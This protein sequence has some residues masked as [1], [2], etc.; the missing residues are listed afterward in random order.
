[1]RLAV[2]ELTY[3]SPGRLEWREAPDPV[4]RY[5][6]DAI[7]RPIASTTCDLDG[8]IIRGRALAMFPGPFAIGHECIAEV[9]ELGPGVGGLYPGQL[10]VVNWHISCGR[11]DRCRGGRPNTCRNH[12]PHACYGLPW[13]ERWGGTFSDLV[14]VPNANFALTPLPAGIDPVHVASAAD[15]LPFGYEFTIPH[16]GAAPGA[17]VLVMGGTG[18]IGLYAAMFAR[19]GGSS[20][21]DYVDTDPARL[22]VAEAL[23]VNAIESPPPRHMTARYPI[24][25]DTSASAEGLQC[26]VRSVEAEGVVSSCGGHFDNALPLPLHEMYVRGVHFYTGRGLGGP[27]VSSALDWVVAGRVRPDLIVSEIAAFDDAP[28]VLAEPGLKP[29]LTRPQAFS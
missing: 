1:M 26:A 29:V 9:A 7:V 18:S 28:M 24:V 11:C 3:L 19:A 6:E 5:P 23:G 2:R 14:R 22:A 15:N 12:P 25:V 20:R 27:N 16:L 17:P 10:V 13:P 21:V 4:L 8:M